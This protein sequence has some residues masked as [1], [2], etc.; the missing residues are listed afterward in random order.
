MGFRS[1]LLLGLLL[2]LLLLLLRNDSSR[3]RLVW[4][5][6]SFKDGQADSTDISQTS[7]HLKPNL[8]R[9]APILLSLG[10]GVIGS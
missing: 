4:L 10:D 1:I 6:Q 5:W 8:R 3:V 7:D 9:R 2:L